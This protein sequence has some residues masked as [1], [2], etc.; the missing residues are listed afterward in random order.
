MRNHPTSVMLFAAGFGTRMKHLTE[1]R[2]KPMIEVSGRPLIAHALD[3]AHEIEPDQI[4]ANLHYKP[5]ML[6]EYLEPR[7]VRAIL[8]EPDILETGGGLKNALPVLGEEP[9][10]TL[11]TDA[12]W[13]GPNPLCL[14]R[15]AWD[16]ARMD[17][18]LVCMTQ[19][20]A[21][22]HSGQGDFRIA[23]SGVLTRGAE[24]IYAGAQVIKTDRLCCIAERTFSLNLLWDMM[25]AEGRLFGLSYPGKW[26]DVGHPDGI[27]AAEK[28][29]VTS[30]V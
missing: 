27:I 25:L 19:N 17:G 18:L 5:Q 15:D 2:P 29:L 21:I 26:C 4:V 30:L 13:S 12:V 22:G 8:E 6:F 24:E 28:L 20:N 9:V 14:L 1:D 10:F 16:P 3:L 11:N 7:G 23:P